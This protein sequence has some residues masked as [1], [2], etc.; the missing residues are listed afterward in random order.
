MAD[1]EGAVDGSPTDECPAIDAETYDEA[2]ES[3]TEEK[4]VEANFTEED[5][6]EEDS[7]LGN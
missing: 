6:A 4:G 5:I 1:A 2:V 7:I 3:R